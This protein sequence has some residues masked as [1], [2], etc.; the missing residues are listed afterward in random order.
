MHACTDCA[1]TGGAIFQLNNAAPEKSPANA[2]FF[3]QRLVNLVG[4]CEPRLAGRE[5]LADEFSVADIA[6]YPI[7]NQRKAAFE[8]AGKFPHLLAWLARVGAR[9]GV[10]KGMQVSV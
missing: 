1:V 8:Q 7:V 4:I 9:P 6:L 2:A 5:Y 10:A 3:E